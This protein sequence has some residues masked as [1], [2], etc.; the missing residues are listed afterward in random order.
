MTTSYDEF[1]KNLDKVAK[2]TVRTEGFQR[3]Y[4]SVL[5]DIKA[6]TGSLSEVQQEQYDNLKAALEETEKDGFSLAGSIKDAMQSA[7]SSVSGAMADMLL[8]LG[9]GF[10]SLQDIALNAV[11]NIIAALIEAQIQKAI[12]GSGMGMSGGIGSILGLGMSAIPG[13]GLL[14]G[15]GAILGGLFEKGGNV[16]SGRKPIVVGERG[17]ELF[18]PGRSG[19]VVSNADM[20]GVGGGESLTVNFNLNAIDTQSGTEFLVQNKRVITGVIQDAY[21]RRAQTGPLG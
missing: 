16:P 4:L 15:A 11:R 2:D 10:E 12:L 5:E 1:I 18:L 8:G 19:S 9:N 7:V 14:V 6:E 13:L 20:A 3:R 17:P 21:R